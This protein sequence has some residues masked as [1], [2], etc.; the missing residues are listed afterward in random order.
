MKNRKVSAVAVLAL[1]ILAGCQAGDGSEPADASS[2]AYEASEGYGGDLRRHPLLVSSD[3]EFSRTAETEL[4][5]LVNDYR[6]THDLAALRVLPELKDLALAHSIH[7]G[8][9]EPAF[10]DHGNPEGDQ[11]L[12]RAKRSIDFTSIGENLAA[13]QSAAEAVFRSWLLSPS[14]RA[15]LEDPRWTHMGAGHAVLPDS[16]YVTYW[17]LDLIQR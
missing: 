10:F 17:T 3:D 4:E 14:H 7:M 2:T 1:A 13:G 12:D 5:F 11:P 15:N 8:R 9:H 6:L 16:P